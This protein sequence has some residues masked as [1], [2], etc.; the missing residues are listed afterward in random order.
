MATKHIANKYTN[1]SLTMR[2][3]G[4]VHRGPFSQ[5]AKQLQLESNIE[6]NSHSIHTWDSGTHPWNIL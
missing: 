1:V 4:I 2:N 6:F 3:Y 5:P